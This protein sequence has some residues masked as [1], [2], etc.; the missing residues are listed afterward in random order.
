MSSF[1][2]LLTIIK[3]SKILVKEKIKKIESVENT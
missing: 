3:V 2:D 1:F